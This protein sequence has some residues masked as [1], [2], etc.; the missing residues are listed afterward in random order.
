[1]S[2][3]GLIRITP[4]G[5][6]IRRNGGVGAVPKK[7]TRGISPPRGM[8]VREETNNGER[9]EKKS[10]L[11]ERRGAVYRKRICPLS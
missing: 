10:N 9:G 3:E 4:E 8:G 5:S 2:C 11:S 1:V 7:F 6:R